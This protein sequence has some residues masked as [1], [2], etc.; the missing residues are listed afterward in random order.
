MAGDNGRRSDFFPAHFGGP[1][2][3]PAMPHIGTLARLIIKYPACHILGKRKEKEKE[4]KEEKMVDAV[5]IQK[6]SALRAPIF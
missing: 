3:F 4:K 2:D 6:L 5:Y 1:A